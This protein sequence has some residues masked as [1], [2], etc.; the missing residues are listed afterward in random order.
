MSLYVSNSKVLALIETFSNSGQSPLAR[1]K[2]IK[3]LSGK[4]SVLTLCADELSA[5]LCP[6]HAQFGE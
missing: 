6:V 1:E 3:N 4:D 2:V 5:T